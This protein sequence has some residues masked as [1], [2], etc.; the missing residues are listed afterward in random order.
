MNTPSVVL[1]SNEKGQVCAMISF[2]PDFNNLQIEDAFK[3]QIDSNENGDFAF[4]IDQAK[5]EF[6]FVLDRS[7]SMSGRRIEKAKEA[8][9][10]FIKSLPGGSYFNIY[11]FGSHFEKIFMES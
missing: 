7:G 9:I 2:V 10:F 8:L 3:A 5:S 6:I 4:N 1:G 11:S